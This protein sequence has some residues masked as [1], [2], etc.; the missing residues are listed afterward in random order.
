VWWWVL[1][2]TVVLL[3]SLA[4]LTLLGIRLFR[5]GVAL[6][7]ELE[8]AATRFSRVADRLD[9]LG[10]AFTPEPSAVFEDPAALRKRRAARDRHGR[11][12]K[13]R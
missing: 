3:G 2:W 11:H 6:G 10:R 8:V 13:S 12:R 7:R 5:Q 4:L 1:V 9:E